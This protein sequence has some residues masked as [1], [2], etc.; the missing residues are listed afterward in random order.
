MELPLY[1]P[2]RLAD[3]SF[4]HTAVERLEEEFGCWITIQ[5]KNTNYL[6]DW[7]V[8]INGT[9]AFRVGRYRDDRGNTVFETTVEQFE[10]RVQKQV[11]ES[12]ES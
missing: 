1:E 11:D 4:I 8:V 6:D 3:G 2:P 10:S 9:E 5:G 7:T 12:V